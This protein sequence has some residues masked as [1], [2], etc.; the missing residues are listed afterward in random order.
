MAS[1]QPPRRFAACPPSKSP[2]GFPPK[3]LAISQEGF[4]RPL[5]VRLQEVHLVFPPKWLATNMEKVC[6]FPAFEK[7]IWFPPQMAGNQPRRF[8]VAAA[9]LPLRSQFRLP[10]NGLLS[11]AKKVSKGRCVPAFI[12]IYAEWS[13]CHQL[14]RVLLETF[15]ALKS[16][17]SG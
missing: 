10:P 8:Q 12:I 9:Y 5:H 16:K 17:Q 7:S 15:L 2:F 6:G 3:W 14:S 1:Y 11:N 4:K 13:I